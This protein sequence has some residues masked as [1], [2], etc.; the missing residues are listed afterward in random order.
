M[1]ND[2]KKENIKENDP[3][4]SYLVNESG[5]EEEENSIGDEKNNFTIELGNY[6]TINIILEDK[7]KIKDKSIEN[8][9]LLTNIPE[10]IN[11]DVE[12]GLSHEENDIVIEDNITTEDENIKEND[13]LVNDNLDEINGNES[14][15]KSKKGGNDLLSFI[16][17]EISDKIEKDSKNDD[18][19]NVSF[20]SEETNN[21]IIKEYD[22][23]EELN[24]N[25]NK[26][27][28][29]NKEIKN[30]NSIIDITS[31]PKSFLDTEQ[32]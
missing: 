6:D 9:V 21:N 18:L 26:I 13:K 19:S 29:N 32:V 22:K 1:E 28:I 31:N 20:N 24:I 5:Y 11:Y 27:Q 4:N 25:D 10:D 12:K 16:S 3:D 23:N 14:D 17:E 2:E 15:N 7:S 30:D 8:N